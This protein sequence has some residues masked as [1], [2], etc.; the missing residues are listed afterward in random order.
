MAYIEQ[1]GA[2]H[3]ALLAEVQGV[4]GRYALQGMPAVERIAV[5]AQAIGA[6]VRQLP[7]GTYTA[8]EIM[9]SVALNIAAGN[10]A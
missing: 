5:L 8:N 9:Y 1:P 10:A 6:E 7:G 3:H 4:L 2:A